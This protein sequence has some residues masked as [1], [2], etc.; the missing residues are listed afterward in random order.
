VTW[1]ASNIP[2]VP[3]RLTMSGYDY[4]CSLSTLSPPPS[5]VTNLTLDSYNIRQFDITLILSWSPPSFPNGVLGPYDVCVG[6]MPLEPT[7]EPE[8]QGNFITNMRDCDTIDGESNGTVKL[9]YLDR[10]DFE[11]LF[12]QVSSAILKS[13]SLQLRIISIIIMILDACIQYVCSG[14]LE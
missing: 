6:I 10:G 1:N 2:Y 3:P 12:I 7:Q 11:D 13:T 4:E 9:S 8:P 5:L 14:Q